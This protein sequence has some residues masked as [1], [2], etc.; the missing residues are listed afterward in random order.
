[1]EV[2]YVEVLMVQQLLQASSY[3][4]TEEETPSEGL[5]VAYIPLRPT[6]HF[7]DSVGYRWARTAGIN[8]CY[9]MGR[10]GQSRGE[11]VDAVFGAEGPN[12]GYRAPPPADLQY[13]QPCYH[14]NGSYL[15]ETAASRDLPTE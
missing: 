3:V 13:L 14:P 8:K 7:N 15:N 12:W 10:L 6:W 2:H 4:Q 5:G 9:L 1:V 11:P